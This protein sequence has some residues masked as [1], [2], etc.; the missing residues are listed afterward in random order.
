MP[1][2]NR[3]SDTDEVF[4][5]SVETCPWRDTHVLDTIGKKAFKCKSNRWIESGSHFAAD[6]A[7]ALANER[8]FPLSESPLIRRVIVPP[9]EEHQ[10]NEDGRGGQSEECQQ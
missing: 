2:K 7:T 8:A 5:P 9:N 1:I 3:N 4:L 6:S 10:Q